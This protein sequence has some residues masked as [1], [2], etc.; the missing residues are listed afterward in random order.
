MLKAIWEVRVPISSLNFNKWKW[1]L[2]WKV[3]EVR[4]KVMSSEF[5]LEIYLK[6]VITFNILLFKRELA[7]N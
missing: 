4:L 5:L 3:N 6:K 1:V 7:D 2:I